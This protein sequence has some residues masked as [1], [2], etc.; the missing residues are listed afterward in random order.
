MSQNQSSGADQ[1]R[2]MPFAVM[3][4]AHEAMRASIALQQTHLENGDAADFNDEWRRFRRALAV[5]MAMED[6]AM[7]DLLDSVGEGAV[8]AAGLPG[9]HVDDMQLADAVDLALENND[10]QALRTAWSVWRGDH[11]SHLEHE[12]QIMMPLVVKTGANP[13]AIARV[14][15]ERLLTPGERLP[16]FDWYVGWVVHM[17]ATYG[18]AGQPA[19]VARRVF[20][21]ALQNVCSPEQWRRLRPVVERNCTPVIWNELVEGF[22]L[23]GEGAMA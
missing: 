17:L 19:N 18:S 2:P 4:N 22:G 10:L 12:E 3:R 20:A 21:W 5:H 1:P 11:L 6:H 15:H 8:T 14:V 23:D 9:E 16:D 7:F 13:Q